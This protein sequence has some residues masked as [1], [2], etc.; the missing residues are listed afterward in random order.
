MQTACF[1]TAG[2]HPKAVAICRFLPRFMRFTGARYLPLAPT[3]A[4]LKLGGAAFEDAYRAQLETLDPRQVYLDLVALVGIDA[5]L[6]CHEKS[7]VTCHRR[8]VAQWLEA[9]L[10]ITVPELEAPSVAEPPNDPKV[11]EYYVRRQRLDV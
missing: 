4:M 10:G 1:R 2:T 8:T 11:T 3:P 6:L 9:A 7:G 5:V